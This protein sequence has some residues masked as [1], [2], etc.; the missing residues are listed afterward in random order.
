MQSKKLFGIGIGV[1]ALTVFA[2]KFF[3]PREPQKYSDKWFE[4]TSDE[5]LKEER[6]VVRQQFCSAG[7]NFQ[8]AATLQ[9]LLWLFD[10]FLSK[11]AWGDKVPRGPGYHREH[12]YNLYKD[13]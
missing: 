6:E 11:R 3:N 1:A 8:L 9:S 4:T 7:D 13:D 10:S 5:I 12:G 2:Y